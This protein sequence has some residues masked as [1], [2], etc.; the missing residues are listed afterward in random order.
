[1]LVS[2]G[3]IEILDRNVKENWELN[4]NYEHISRS[5]N[6]DY[7]MIIDITKSNSDQKF[8]KYTDVLNSKI[9]T[10]GKLN[11]CSK[12]RSSSNVPNIILT[13]ERAAIQI[14]ISNQNKKLILEC[15]KYIDREMNL[16]SRNS[17]VLLTRLLKYKVNTQNSNEPVREYNEKRIYDLLFQEVLRQEN[18]EG[19]QPEDLKNL[20]TS[21]MLIDMV[22]PK[23]GISDAFITDD[24]I[25]KLQIVTKSSRYLTKEENNKATLMLSLFIITLSILIF[26]FNFNQLKSKNINKI[27]KLFRLVLK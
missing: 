26:I 2:Y 3:G 1:M 4:L 27:K 19:L 15:E 24:K 23:E 12:I 6:V 9:S 17:K 20:A 18:K 7:E 14:V 5:L 16:F 8:N 22:S 21:L 11:P 13:Y 25:N 10:P